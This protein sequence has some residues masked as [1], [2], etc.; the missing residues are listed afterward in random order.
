MPRACGCLLVTMIELLRMG[1][2]VFCVLA[3]SPHDR[4]V[5]RRSPATRCA[6]GSPGGGAVQGKGGV[7]GREVLGIDP[8]NVGMVHGVH[9]FYL[10]CMRVFE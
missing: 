2:H 8:P 7:T 6:A 5:S 10:A 1:I 9:V 3:L 4:G